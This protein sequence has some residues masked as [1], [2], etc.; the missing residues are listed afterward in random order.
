LLDGETCRRSSRSASR[1]IWL[2]DPRV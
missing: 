2:S 1:T